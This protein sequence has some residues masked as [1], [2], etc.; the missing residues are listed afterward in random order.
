MKQTML[1]KKE[2]P[3]LDYAISKLNPEVFSHPVWVRFG[4][5]GEGNYLKIIEVLFNTAQKLR[6]DNPSDA[7]QLML[8]CSVFQIHANQHQNALTT[9][10]HV[11]ALAKRTSLTREILWAN[12]GACAICVQ[13]GNYDQA[14]I[15][16]EDL[17]IALSGQNE[18]ILADFVDVVKQ[19]LLD[20]DP[21]SVTE[22]LGSSREQAI[23]DL[24]SLTSDWLQKWGTAIQTSEEELR[25]NTSQQTTR[26]FQQKGLSQASFSSLPQRGYWNTLKLAVRGELSL[27]W[28]EKDGNHTKERL[29]FWQSV[30]NS[31]RLS[32]SG[33]IIEPKI[34]QDV[35]QILSV[36]NSPPK[37]SFPAL[38]SDSINNP[39]L[40]H[41]T[42]FI[43][44]T[45]QMLE[46][47][48]ITVQDSLLKLH[49]TRGLSLLKY[50][51][52]HHKQNTPR[53]VLMDIFW[54]DADPDAAR[55]NLNVAMHGLRQILRTVTDVEIIH[56]EDGAYGLSPDLEIW[57][58]VEE[59][60]RC[61]KTGQRLEAQKQMTAAV[62]EYE[63][64]I[65]LYRGEFLADTPYEGWTVLDRER[66]RIAYLDTIDHLSQIYFNQER[67]SACVT[68]C[69]LILT[70]DLCREDAH[71][72]LM[73]CY[74]R[75]G[76]GP[77]ALRQYQT[78]VEALRAELEV[79]PAPETI[80]LYNHIRRR[81]HI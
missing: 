19:S 39:I 13:Q 27:Q 42:N 64:A 9:V 63:I 69:Q 16:L 49:A 53:E 74:S 32:Q 25:V 45:V 52:L 1:S 12:W 15:H 70:R 55:N 68:L 56:F 44:M 51:L 21:T 31:L 41:T 46:H 24:L 67:Y 2:S 7:C 4:N 77:L 80:Q 71:C 14:T 34:A 18:W 37:V 33:R 26:T 40:E 62:A 60:D 10:Q 66:L 38:I 6:D 43:P 28:V 76:Q 22:R 23:V 61:I 81:E 73:Q 35:P 54:P 3:L 29:S 8:V 50:L 11:L 36:T 75:L 58:D 20:A 48:S 65:N 30:L 5:K 57:L 79:E 47:F 72:R 78:C 59:F 17:Q